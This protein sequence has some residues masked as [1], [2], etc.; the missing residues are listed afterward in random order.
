MPWSKVCAAIHVSFYCSCRS[1]DAACPSRAGAWAGG[2]RRQPT[3][4]RAGVQGGGPR[5][6]RQLRPAV[7][8]RLRKKL[9]R[10]GAGD[11]SEVSE[12][13]TFTTVD[14]RTC[15]VPVNRQIGL[16]RSRLVTRLDRRFCSSSSSLASRAPVPPPSPLSSRPHR[17]RKRITIG[18]QLGDPGAAERMPNA[19]GDGLLVPTPCAE[20]AR[21]DL[22]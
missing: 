6:V 14:L 9:P 21:L 18:E 1:A 4:R 3:R 19:G 10:T 20:V 8:C 7:A 15:A 11:R 16:V 13:T 12:L 17:Q 5:E 22:R 2:R